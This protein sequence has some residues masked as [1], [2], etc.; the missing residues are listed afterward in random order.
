[1]D[2]TP[3]N[4]EDAGQ[5]IASYFDVTLDAQKTVYSVLDAGPYV[6]PGRWTPPWVV[7]CPHSHALSAMGM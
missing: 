6:H 2:G 4:T 5:D 1:M 7:P 3:N